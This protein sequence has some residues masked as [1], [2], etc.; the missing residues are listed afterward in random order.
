MAS[1]LRLASGMGPTCPGLPCLSVGSALYRSFV[2][3]TLTIY[4][5][6][7]TLDDN[8]SPF[9]LNCEDEQQLQ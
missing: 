9:P 1:Q 6:T 5:L 7:V 8:L 2:S 4:L 3:S